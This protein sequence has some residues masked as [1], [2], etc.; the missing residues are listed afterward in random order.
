MITINLQTVKL[1]DGSLAHNVVLTDCT[2]HAINETDAAS[3]AHALRDA[4]NTYAVDETRI[5]YSEAKD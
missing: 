1:T 3:I 4:I 5:I 2:I